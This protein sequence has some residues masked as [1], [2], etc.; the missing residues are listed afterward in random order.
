MPCYMP[1]HR[2]SCAP[3]TCLLGW[4]CLSEKQTH[5]NRTRAIGQ[6]SGR[7]APGRSDRRSGLVAGIHRPQPGH[8]GQQFLEQCVRQKA[9]EGRGLYHLC[10][11]PRRTLGRPHP[12]LRPVSGECRQV[13]PAQAGDRRSCVILGRF[14]FYLLPIKRFRKPMAMRQGLFSC[15]Y[16]TALQETN[17]I[18]AM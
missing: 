18:S 17:G 16:R 2:G 7:F 15:H 11:S 13:T 8:T 12:A 5:G 10:H 6:G 9:G 14:H 4:H 1:A 3:S